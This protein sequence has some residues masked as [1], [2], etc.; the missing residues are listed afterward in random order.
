VSL[1]GQSWGGKKVKED[2][3]RTRKKKSRN[4]DTWYMYDANE[5][6]KKGGSKD[7]PKRKNPHHARERKVK[8]K[9]Q[10]T[11]QG[12]SGPPKDPGSPPMSGWSRG[13][14]KMKT[15]G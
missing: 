9:R 4:Q 10:S 5:M 2:G 14:I 8:K 3:G 1:S 11:P 7:F 13:T 6:S 12:D 15:P